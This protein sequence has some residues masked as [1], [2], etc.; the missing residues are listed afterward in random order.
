[1]TDRIHH[2]TL[3]GKGYSYWNTS[4]RKSGQMI[5]FWC[6]ISATETAKKI[7]TKYCNQNDCFAYLLVNANDHTDVQNNFASLVEDVGEKKILNVS[8]YRD[9][10]K[11]TP[12]ARGSKGSKGSV[13]DQDIFLI[14]GDH[15][16][17]SPLNYDY[18]D[19]TLMRSLSTERLNDLQDEDEIVYIPILR[20]GTATNDYPSINGLYSHKDFFEK[21]KVFDNTNIY[22][23]KHGVVDRLIKEGYNLVDFNTWFKTRLK[24]L[25]DNK[26]KDIYQFNSLVEQCRNEYNSDDKMNRGYGQGYIDRQFLFHM[27]NMFGLEYDQ[28]INNNKIVSTLDS[29]MI[30]EFFADTI[31]RQEFD[32]AKFKKDDYYGHMTKLLS[33]FGINGLDSVKIKDANVI[34]NQINRIID[35]IYDNDK[36]SQYTQIFKKA[37]SD[38]EY[39]APKIADLR[40]TIK[41]ELDNNP[42][43][44]YTMCVTS[45]SGNLR[46]LRNVNPLKQNDGSRGHYYTSNNGWFSTINDLD[47]LKVQFGQMIG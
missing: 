25:N 27:L 20:Y 4:G 44:K 18:N 33:D 13:S 16:N 17:T 5:F 1:M 46:E 14:F 37:E 42:I 45:V 24:K 8:D 15:K 47:K 11:S 19:A 29:L 43:L 10:I 23:I 40:K 30:L 21:Y 28:F 22:A 36:I 39:V 31:H 7:V 3:T 32:I 26:F 6:D 41:A 9:L 34:Y 35:N 12:K 2:D 38:N